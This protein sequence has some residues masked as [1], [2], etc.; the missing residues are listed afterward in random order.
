MLLTVQ[1]V[2]CALI[3][4]AVVLVQVKNGKMTTI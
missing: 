4:I 3:L 2:G 1:L